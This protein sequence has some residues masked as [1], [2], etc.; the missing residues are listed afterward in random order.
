M[1]PLK[2]INLINQSKR[3]QKKWQKSHCEEWSLRQ[4]HCFGFRRGEKSQLTFLDFGTQLLWQ[5]CVLH[6]QLCIAMCFY[7]YAYLVYRSG[8]SSFLAVM[9]SWRHPWPLIDDRA[10]WHPVSCSW[11]PAVWNNKQGLN[12]E[13]QSDRGR[14]RFQALGPNPGFPLD[15]QCL[16]SLSSTDRRRRV[17][18]NLSSLNSLSL[19]QPSV[20]LTHLH[21]YILIFS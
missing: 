20:L 4:Q 2:W 9:K 13:G 17:E 11:H 16:A 19:L 21:S 15:D 14:L 3:Q 6:F 8:G 18:N 10:T 12:V 1:M 5:V 7:F